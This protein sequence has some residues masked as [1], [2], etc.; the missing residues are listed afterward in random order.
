LITS[1]DDLCVSMIGGYNT[2]TTHPFKDHEVPPHSVNQV[3]ISPEFCLWLRST[4]PRRSL[5]IVKLIWTFVR[6]DDR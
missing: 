5:A 4:S 1:F 3:Y 6:M 2:E